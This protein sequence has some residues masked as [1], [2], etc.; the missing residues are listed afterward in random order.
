M[1]LFIVP[2]GCSTVSRRSRI[3]C[4]FSI[5]PLLRGLHHV[6]VLPTGDD[7][8]LSLRAARLELAAT[9]SFRRVTP[10]GALSIHRCEP[11]GQQLASRAAINILLGQ[12]SCQSAFEWDPL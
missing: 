3:A 7:P 8:V 10:N 5:Q 4:G 9:T 11:I 2:N 6:L 12:I 1:R